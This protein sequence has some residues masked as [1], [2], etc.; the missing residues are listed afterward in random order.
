MLRAK[1]TVVEMIL[2]R[3]KKKYL[4]AFVSGRKD[5]LHLDLVGELPFDLFDK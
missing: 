1:S 4:K 5:G 2:N 3:K